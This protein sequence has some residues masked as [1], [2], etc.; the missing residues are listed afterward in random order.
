MHEA[1]KN[2]FNVQKSIK[3]KL[4]DLN[5]TNRIPKIIAVSKNQ[6]SESVL[7]AINFGVK[8]FGE[9]RVQEALK[10]FVPLKKLYKDLKLHLLGP[11]QSNKV[12]DALSLFD[13]IHTLDR[14]KLAKEIYKHKEILNNKSLFVQINMGKEESKNGLG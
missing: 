12:L 6:S 14:E 1:V 4:L 9:N 10:K 11:L 3:S 2:L 7:E 5:H 8:I 13:V